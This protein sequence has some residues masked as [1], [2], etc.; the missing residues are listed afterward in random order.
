LCARTCL[1]AAQFKQCAGFFLAGCTS[2][3]KCG[4]VR[5]SVGEQGEGIHSSTKKHQRA[6]V[7]RTLASHR[8]TKD[9]VWVGDYN[10]PPARAP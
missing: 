7:H 6:A 9:C 10:L 1:L 4:Q 5:A 3:F 2:Y 8:C